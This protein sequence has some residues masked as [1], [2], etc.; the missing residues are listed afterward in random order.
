MTSAGSPEAEAA[1]ALAQLVR[2]AG[3]D[4]LAT[5]ARWTGDLGLAEDAVQDAS[6][7]ALTAWSRDGVPENPVAWLRLVARRRATDLVRRELAR[8]PKESAAASGERH[9]T[10]PVAA[11]DDPEPSVARDDALRLLFTCCHPALSRDAQVALALRTLCGLSVAECARALLVSESAMAKR[12][13]RTRQKIATAGIP[14]RVPPDHELPERWAGVLNTVH[15]L[16]NEGHTAT[17]GDAVVRQDLVDEA[18]RLARWLRRLRPDDPGAMGLLALGLL[19][20]SRRATRVDAAGEVVLLDRQDRSRW[21]ADEIREAVVLV[22]EGLRHTPTC[23]DR[24]VVQAAVAA[25]H[26]VAPTWEDTD[27]AALVSWYDVLLGVDPS[28]VA[29]LNRAVAV[30]ERDGAAAGLEA[31]DAVRGLERYPLR[32]AARAALLRRLGRDAEAEEAIRPAADL[33]MSLPQRRLVQRDP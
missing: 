20:D 32:H 22:G 2:S 4:V 1:A 26:A 24:Y 28:P 29:E 31:L 11:M 12:L 13:F 16:L 19:V 30:G 23:P 15:L 9:W 10:D 25:C 14:Y 3:R 21:D 17:D 18:I 27:W 33:P 6:L 8:R 5:V 7:T